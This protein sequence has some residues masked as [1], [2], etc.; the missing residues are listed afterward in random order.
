MSFTTTITTRIKFLGSSKRYIGARLWIWKVVT[1][2]AT[3]GNRQR[4][5]SAQILTKPASK[6]FHS[7]AGIRFL[8]DPLHVKVLCAITSNY[9]FIQSWRLQLQTFIAAAPVAKGRL[10][11]GKFNTAS[12]SRLLEWHARWCQT[13]HWDAAQKSARDHRASVPVVVIGVRFVLRSRRTQ[14]VVLVWQSWNARWKF[15]FISITNCKRCAW[16]VSDYRCVTPKESES[17]FVKNSIA[18]EVYI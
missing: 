4:D 16:R 1:H 8:I 12:H 7:H 9:F 2:F 18:I 17:L 3:I 6:E 14:L 5:G 10:A 15:A 13:S 11:A